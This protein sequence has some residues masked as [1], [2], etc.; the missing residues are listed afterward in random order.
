MPTD[1]N[2]T[3]SP[4]APLPIFDFSSQLRNGNGGYPLENKLVP[5]ADRA[6]LKFDAKQGEKLPETI[7]DKIEEIRDAP[8]IYEKV[9]IA[10]SFANAFIKPETQSSISSEMNSLQSTFE[11]F[12]KSK[13]PRGDCD[14]YARFKLGLLVRAGVDQKNILFAT[15]LAKFQT[16]SK[17]ITTPHGHLIVRDEDGHY[18][19]A[20]NNLESITT[21][22]PENP[23]FEGTLYVHPS[24][25]KDGSGINH[26]PLKGEVLFFANIVDGNYTSYQNDGANMELMKASGITPEQL[27]KIGEQLQMPQELQMPENPLSIPLEIPPSRPQIQHGMGGGVA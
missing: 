21:I 25:Q 9:S 12:S 14:D 8:S 16:D 1:T 7:A 3:I 13:N 11:E 5:E 17:T 20:D 24:L 23:V 4:D 15:G 27:K 22:D 10:H 6:I 2:T 26:M 18:L 19:L